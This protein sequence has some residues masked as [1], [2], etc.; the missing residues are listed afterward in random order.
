MKKWEFEPGDAVV[1][2]RSEG[3]EEGVVTA[4]AGE[5]RFSARMYDV[6]LNSGEVKAFVFYLIRHKHEEVKK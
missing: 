3:N 5:N 4:Y 6:K 1:V 2:H